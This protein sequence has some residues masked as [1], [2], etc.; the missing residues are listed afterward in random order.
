MKDRNVCCCIYH[1]EMEELRVGFNFMRKL[2][3]IY[4]NNTCNCD[5]EEVCGGRDECGCK[6]HF[7]TFP[8][9][10]SMMESIL[11]PLDKFIEWHD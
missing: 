6:G 8:G 5:C 9:T 10:T 2:S 3:D 11:C 7:L 4:A 1:V